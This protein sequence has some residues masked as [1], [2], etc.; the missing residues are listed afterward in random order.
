MGI[1]LYIDDQPWGA[2]TLDAM[3]PG[4]FDTINPL[5]L[6]AF[7]RLTEATVKAAERMDQLTA[8]AE[9]EH[10][11]ARNFIEDVGATE[12][13][14]NSPPMRAM[15]EELE[16]VAKS[17]LIVLILGETGV[18]KELVAHQIH[19]HSPRANQPMVQVNCAA[20]PEN[21]AE[22]E[23]FGHTKGAF[24]GATT[25]RAGKFEIADGGT[26]FLDE[27]GEL[28][29]PIQAKML[30]VLQSGEIQRVGSDQTIKVDVRVVAAT[31]RDL[32]KEV[33]DGRFRADLYHRISVY[34]ITV[35]PL[36]ER[37]RDVLLLA[38]FLLETNQRRLGAQGLHLDDSAKQALQ[39]YQWPGNVRELE[40]LLSRSTLK[41]V[42]EQGRDSRTITLSLRH[43]DIDLSAAAGLSAAPSPALPAATDLQPPTL[44]EAIDQFQRELIRQ[45]MA[46]HNNN[47]A[48]VAREL[49]LNRSNFSRLLQ[50]LDLR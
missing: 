27:I 11:V 1:S 2:L 47:Q 5:E 18:G 37:G 7:I 36:R 17:H 9:R 34:P 21:I 22:S 46:K 20:L 13:I 30:R 19:R 25:D 33:A 41:A 35:P 4:T 6:R 44:K 16:I 29:L 31:N 10:Q 50:R 39:Q 32:Q 48:A 14:G 24:T 15:K 28:S 43:L 49:G 8:R 12:I 42:A 3:Q 45:Q 23:L 26:L 38:G 40:H